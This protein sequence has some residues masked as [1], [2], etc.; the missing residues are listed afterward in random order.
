M[1][2]KDQAQASIYDRDRANR[3]L[4]FWNVMYPPSPLYDDGVSTRPPMD[5][6]PRSIDEM[7][8]GAPPLVAQ[9]LREILEGA[10]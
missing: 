6:P 10:E 2:A 3:L 9:Q 8:E 5:L 7:C 4:N 1:L